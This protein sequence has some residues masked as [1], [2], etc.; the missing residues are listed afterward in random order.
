MYG[1]KPWE[2]RELLTVDELRAAVREVKAA[3]EAQEKR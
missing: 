1:I 3:I 2:Q